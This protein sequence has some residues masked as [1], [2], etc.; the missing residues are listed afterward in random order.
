MIVS[1]MSCVE[2]Y[3]N[4]VADRPKIEIKIEYLR[5]K[6]IKELKKAR[7][8]P[9]VVTYKYKIP[10]TLNEHIIYFY[11]ESRYC[12][13][14]PIA[15]SFFV[16][17]ENTRR[18]IFTYCKLGY[19]TENDFIPVKNINLY[20]RHFFERYEERYLKDKSLTSNEIISLYLSRN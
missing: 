11:A 12:A 16:L 9:A 13:H 14:K 17:Y 4:L 1:R 6:A 2:M 7:K 19:I 3:D 18:Y 8:F 10:A 5:S 15:D 20:T